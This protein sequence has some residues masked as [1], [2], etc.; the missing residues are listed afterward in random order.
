MKYIYGPVKSRRLGLS[1][2]VSL[3]PYKLCTFDCVYCQLGRSTEKSIAR[4]EYVS[5]QEILDELKAWLANNPGEAKGLNY[6][7]LSGSGEPTL[8]IK[9]GELISQIKS[10]TPVPLAVLTNSS[11]LSDP[12][13]RRE[14]LPADLIVPSLD[15]ATAEVFA[16]IDRP[17]EGISIE[18]IISALVSLRQE[19][20]GKIWLEAML[21]RGINDD[22]RQIKKM[23]EATDAINPDKITLN[24]PVRSTAEPGIFAVDKSK[25]KKIRDIFGDKCEII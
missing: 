1:L 6:V 16:R 9:A 5:I 13:L 24:S 15:A 3:T 11:L 18:K 2:G 8:N 20:R 23:K 14:L 4:K 10:I 7:T 25:L 19:F 21:V 17:S 12:G 22:L